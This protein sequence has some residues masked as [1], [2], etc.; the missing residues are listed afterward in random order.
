MN[1]SNACHI[2]ARHSSIRLLRLVVT[3]LEYHTTRA[4][5]R[6]NLVEK[7]R[8]YDKAKMLRLNQHTRT[9]AFQTKI[10]LNPGQGQ[11]GS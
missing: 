6:P 7:H 11:R 5:G 2:I 9:A 1:T 3:F 8:C 4:G 10:L